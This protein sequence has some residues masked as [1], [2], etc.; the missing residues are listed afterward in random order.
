MQI[1]YTLADSDD[2]ILYKT[3]GRAKSKIATCAADDDRLVHARVINRRR[4]VL[5]SQHAFQYSVG[6]NE[7]EYYYH[8]YIIVIKGAVVL[9]GRRRHAVYIYNERAMYNIHHKTYTQLKLGHL[10]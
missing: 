3:H 6:R 5:F 9:F 8:R 4:R 1:K 2:R 7:C 10:T